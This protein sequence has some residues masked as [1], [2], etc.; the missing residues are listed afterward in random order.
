MK[1]FEYFIKNNCKYDIINKFYY[2]TLN[3]LP[4]VSKICLNIK[5]QDSQM[6]TFITSLIALELVT[7]QKSTIS[8]FKKPKL[9]LNIKDGILTSCMVTLRKHLMYSFLK[10]L[11]YEILPQSQ[12][13][14][15]I[16]L[17]SSYTSSRSVTL[18]LNQMIDISEL[19]PHF[20]LFKNLPCLN[21]TI[22][23]NDSKMFELNYIFKVFKLSKS[24]HW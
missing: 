2:N 17:K 16:N 4:K 9:R 15:G 10:K 19:E 8:S 24:K 23:M 12:E 13:F 1:N 14:N 18:K 3:K 5:L 20:L 11:I 21:I 7:S 22:V 6:F